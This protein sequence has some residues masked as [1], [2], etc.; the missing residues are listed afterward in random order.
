M[1]SLR[2]D[3]HQFITKILETPNLVN[4]VGCPTCICFFTLGELRHSIEFNR[5][6]R[7]FHTRMPNVYCKIVEDMWQGEK[8]Y[9][10]S[11]SSTFYRYCLTE[12]S[13][14]TNPNLSLSIKWEYVRVYTDK[15]N[16]T[17]V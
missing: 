14:K 11:I 4:S 17:T 8:E 3:L 15:T 1:F 10:S 2:L 12:L 5:V 7:L 9:L 16:D 6:S 13:S